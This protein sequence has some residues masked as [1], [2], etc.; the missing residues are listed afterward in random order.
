MC[1]LLVTFAKELMV[2]LGLFV[3][4]EEQQHFLSDPVTSWWDQM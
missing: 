3:V 2:Y 1:S 4:V